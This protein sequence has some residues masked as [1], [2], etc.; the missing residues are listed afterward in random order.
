MDQILLVGINAAVI[1]IILGALLGYRF[2][3]TKAPATSTEAL[4]KLAALEAT[5]SALNDQL[6]KADAQ[7][8][9]QRQLTEQENKILLQLAPVKQQLEQMQTT[10]QRLERERG[11]QFSS[12]S[13]QLRSAIETDE[14]LRRQTQQLAQAL[15][16][17]SLRGVWGEAQLRRLVELAGLLKHADFGEEGGER[18]SF[19]ERGNLAWGN[20]KKKFVIFPLGEGLARG[21]PRSQWE[22]FGVD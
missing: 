15:S 22:F 19:T 10:V 4:T 11:E 9:Q 20:R 17:N 1:G 7:L 16:S 3:K 12:I 13:E 14:N 8:A 6:A 2:A 18:P 21:G 5:N